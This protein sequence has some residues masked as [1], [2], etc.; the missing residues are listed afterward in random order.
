MWFV[1]PYSFAV[2]HVVPMLFV[3]ILL[4]IASLFLLAPAIAR[5]MLLLVLLPYALLALSASFQQARCYGA[6]LILAMPGL[7][8]VYHLI[9]G[10]GGVWGLCQL[11]LQRAPVQRSKPNLKTPKSSLPKIDQTRC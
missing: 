5:V 1:A 4:F 3:I 7:F 2:R 10:A 9:Y 8:L 11:L 6:H